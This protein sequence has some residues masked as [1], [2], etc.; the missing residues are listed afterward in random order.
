[1]HPYIYTHIHPYI[2][3]YIMHT[4]DELHGQDRLNRLYRIFATVIL[5]NNC[6]IFLL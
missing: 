6:Q 5:S 3:T 4:L 1:M 2:Y